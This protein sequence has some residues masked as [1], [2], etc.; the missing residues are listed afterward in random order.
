MESRLYPTWEQLESQHSSL[1]IGENTLL[2]FLDLHLPK[3]NNWQKGQKLENYDG[4]LFFTQPYLNGSR[5]DIVIFNP[6]VGVVINEVK[7]WNLYNYEMNGTTLYVNDGNGSYRIKSPY[8]QVIH[9][10]N[11][12]IGQLIPNIGE[13]I[14][15]GKQIGRA[16]V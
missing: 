1:T 2:Q 8:D 7:D 15:T 9:Y 10:K 12:L 6:Q 13:D 14:V 3:D 4:W 11:K 5:P 16:H